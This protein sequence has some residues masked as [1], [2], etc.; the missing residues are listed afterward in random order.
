MKINEIKRLEE[1]LTERNNI[2]DTKYK[3]CYQSLRTFAT[4]VILENRTTYHSDC[5]KSLTNKTN[6]QKLKKTWRMWKCS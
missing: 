3:D 6:I 1:C 5:Y 4:E 2:D